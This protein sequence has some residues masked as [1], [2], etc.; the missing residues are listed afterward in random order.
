MTSI[1][2]LTVDL[3]VLAGLTV[4]GYLV[5]RLILPDRGWPETLALSFPIGAGTTSWVVFVWSWLGLQLSAPSVIGLWLVASLAA[6]FVLRMREIPLRASTRAAPSAATNVGRI[7]SVVA[8]AATGALF[9]F[10]LILTVGRAQAGW[11]AMAIWSAKGYGIALEG[12]IQAARHWGGHGLSYPLNMPIL[13]SFFAL[14]DGDALPG[15]KLIFPLFYAS[16]LGGCFLF[17]RRGK[18]SAT[19]S[20]V[21]ML[22][23]ASVPVLYDHATL[24]YANLPEACYLV[25]GLLY[26]LQGSLERSR[27][28]LLVSSLLLG[29]AMWT[30]PEG[31]IL[32][33]VGIAALAVALR[34]S[35]AEQIRG[36]VWLVP[37]ALVGGTWLVFV[38]RYAGGSQF[39]G[40]IRGAWTGWANGEFNLFALRQIATYTARQAVSPSVWGVAA[41]LLLVLIWI[42]RRHLLPE[43]G[44]AV[45]PILMMGVV[46]GMAV[47]AFY[48][49]ASYADPP[50]DWWLSTGLNR[51]AIPSVCLV[52]VGAFLGLRSEPSKVGR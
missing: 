42:G 7:V 47:L 10:S 46:S 41:P 14:F 22:T 36:G 43:A 32:V 24:G 3:A 6:G 16:L 19:L 5:V 30:R 40:T 29:L 4:L 48:Y 20:S 34:L 12:S 37:V 44:S 49:L 31:V 39:G 8:M 2:T 50:L 33:I 21:G 35:G 9:L 15:S 18:L 17:W 28:A 25:L 26:L 27:R 38:S 1:S 11:D 23:L 45:L 13:I 51:T 52:A